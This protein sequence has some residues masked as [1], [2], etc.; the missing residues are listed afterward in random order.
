MGACGYYRLPKETPTVISF[1]ADQS[2]SSTQWR[3]YISDWN[4]PGTNFYAFELEVYE[5]RQAYL[6]YHDFFIRGTLFKI[7]KSSNGN[8]SLRK[9][10]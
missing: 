6:E 8:I 7:V 1:N 9:I 3:W 10:E 5:S 4:N 2:K